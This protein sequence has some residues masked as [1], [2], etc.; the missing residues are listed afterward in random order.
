ML[1]MFNVIEQLKKIATDI[2]DTLPLLQPA[3]IY[4]PVSHTSNSNHWPNLQVN[5]GHLLLSFL[6]SFKLFLK[7]LN[8]F[9]DMITEVCSN[10]CKIRRMQSFRMWRRV[11]LV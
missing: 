4:W 11:H 2:H 5:L 1:I 3:A 8:S 7:N 10:K 9:A 6:F